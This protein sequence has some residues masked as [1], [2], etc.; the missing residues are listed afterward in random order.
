MSIINEALK[1]AQKDKESSLHLAGGL[2]APIQFQKKHGFNWGPIFVLLVL[3]LITGPIVAPFFAAPFKRE[4]TAGNYALP[5]VSV[6]QGSSPNSAIR[7]PK[8]LVGTL[9][10]PARKGQFGI[11]E[12][13][14]LPLTPGPIGAASSA[15]FRRNFSLSGIVYS[16]KGSYCIINDK[17]VKVGEHVNGATLLAITPEKVMLDYQG[18]TISLV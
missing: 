9:A 7:V 15:N 8:D 16:P 5:T 3:F 13:T 11:E 14:L 6:G 10:G 18:Q 1:K 12:S 4:A 2:G 17:I